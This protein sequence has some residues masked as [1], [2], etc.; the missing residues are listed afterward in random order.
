MKQHLHI[1]K[2]RI[3]NYLTFSI[4]NYIVHNHIQNFKITVISFR[5]TPFEYWLKV[6]LYGMCLYFILA[7]VY[8]FVMIKYDNVKYEWV[9]YGLSNPPIYSSAAKLIE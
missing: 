8:S 1:N 9:C 6:V 2:L 3:H 7:V 4:P 5:I